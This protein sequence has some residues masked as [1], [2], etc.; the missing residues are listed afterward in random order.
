[1][2]TGGTFACIPVI[3]NVGCTLIR[4][5]DQEAWGSVSEEEREDL[6]RDESFIAKSD[7]VVLRYGS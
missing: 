1:M 5:M 6:G 2:Y 7:G 4:W 3:C